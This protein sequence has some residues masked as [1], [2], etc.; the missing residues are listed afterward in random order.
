MGGTRVFVGVH[1]GTVVSCVLVRSEGRSMED[2]VGGIGRSHTILFALF[3]QALEAC[4]LSLYAGS[5]RALA[6]AVLLEG[7]GCSGWRARL[8]R[9]TLP[10]PSTGSC[11]RSDFA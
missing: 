6:A 8:R 4:R 11:R 10:V 2:A 7:G 1:R 9:F 3:F 5:V